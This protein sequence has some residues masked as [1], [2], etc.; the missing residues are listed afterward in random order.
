MAPARPTFPDPLPAEL[1]PV[2]EELLAIAEKRR[3]NAVELLQMLRFLEN[4][5]HWLRDTY[6]MEA[7]PT[8]R[9][10]LFDL[11]MQMEQQG[12]WPNLPRTQLRSLLARLT[13]SGPMGE[14]PH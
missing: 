5:H 9:Q 14:N 13:Q 3:G 4:F 11:L 7:L 2:C 12:N 8:N 10:E 1:E 6:Y